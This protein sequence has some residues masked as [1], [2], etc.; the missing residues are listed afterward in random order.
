[1][2]DPELRNEIIRPGCRRVRVSPPVESRDVVPNGRAGDAPSIHH[3]TQDRLH[4]TTDSPDLHRRIVAVKDAEI[5]LADHVLTVSEL[6]RRTYLDAG[7]PPE[8]LVTANPS[9]IRLR[10][11]DSRKR[12]VI[13]VCS[14]R[15]H[16]LPT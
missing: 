12:F 2:V 9:S 11:S 15:L 3:A 16:R 14:S 1:M 10:P 8:K 7:V 4:G 6:A 13:V 5:A